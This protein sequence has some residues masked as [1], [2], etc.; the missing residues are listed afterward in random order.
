MASSKPVSAHC[1][2]KM[3]VRDLL[4]DN[5]RV[6]ILW[7]SEVYGNADSDYEPT[8]EWKQNWE[9]TT[10]AQFVRKWL[11]LVI[12]HLRADDCEDVDT[13]NRLFGFRWDEIPYPERRAKFATL[14]EG[15]E[16]KYLMEYSQELTFAHIVND[17]CDAGEGMDYKAILTTKDAER[18]KSNQWAIKM[19][20]TASAFCSRHKVDFASIPFFN[21]VSREIRQ[22][23]RNRSDYF[24]GEQSAER[25]ATYRACGSSSYWEDND[26]M[27]DKL[28]QPIR[29]LQELLRFCKLKLPCQYALW[30]ESRKAK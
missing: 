3:T 8:G 24:G 10:V 4:A 22:A 11:D 26:Y 15:W 28:S 7:S 9:T 14:P 6:C 16:E 29:K 5:R 17:W 13:F 2:T 1:E 19:N 30:R 27:A 20:E 12:S 25:Y 21:A 18:Y 23:K